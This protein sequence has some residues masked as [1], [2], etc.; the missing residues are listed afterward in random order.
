MA[1]SRLAELKA[2]ATGMS[3]TGRVRSLLSQAAGGALAA[4]AGVAAGTH[5]CRVLAAQQHCAMAPVV[6]SLAVLLVVLAGTRWCVGRQARMALEHTGCVGRPARMALEHTA[7]VGRLARMAVQ[8]AG[9]GLQQA[10]AVKAA[11]PAPAAAVVLVAG[12]MWR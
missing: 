7:C 8:H 5:L 10:A 3:A 1:R 2:A 9:G 11:V 4:A 6:L 12:G